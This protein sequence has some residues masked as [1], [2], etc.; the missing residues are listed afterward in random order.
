MA[1]DEIRATVAGRRGGAWAKLAGVSVATARNGNVQIAYEVIG[2]GEPLLLIMGLGMQMIAWP[3]EFCAGL[4]ARGFAVARFDN[5]DVGQST[6]FTRYGAPSLLQILTRPTLV[7]PYR[8]EDMADDAVAVLDALGWERAHIVGASLGG[9][10]AQTLAIRHSARVRTLTSI[11]STPSKRVGRPAL[12]VLAALGPRRVTSREAAGQRAVDVFRIIGSPGYPMDEALLREMGER[13]YDR[14]QEP[15]GPQRQLA[16]IHAAR[17]RR[18]GL[19]AVRVPTLVLHGAAD[20]LVRPS[21]GRATAA[22][23]PG[24]RLVIYPGMGHDLPRPLWPSFIDE[25]GTL[26]TVGGSRR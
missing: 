1:I 6:H 5:R 4:V 25:I 26:A 11:M 3:D 13:S 7:A 24:A 9:M 15:T 18:P 20:R 21:G 2:S 16:A 22:A 10:I 19:A 12:S 17:D 14:A 8:L 23:V